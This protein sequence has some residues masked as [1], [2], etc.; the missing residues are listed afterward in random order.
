MDFKTAVTKRANFIQGTNGAIK[1]KTSE[2]SFVDAFTDFNKDTPMTYI[3]KHINII[4]ENGYEIVSE[5]TKPIGQIE[6]CFDDAFLGLYENIE[7]IKELNTPIH[8]FV[9]SSYLE[10]ENYINSFLSSVKQKMQ[11]KRK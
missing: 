10:K 4:R 1:L 7:L 11:V 2:S 8:L 6:I 9:V 3:E 5:I